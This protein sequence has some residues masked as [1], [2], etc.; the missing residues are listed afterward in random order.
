MASS[1]PIAS[2]LAQAGGGSSGFS[3]GG[4]GGGGSFSGSSG[5]GSGGSST[6]AWVFVGLAVLAVVLAAVVKAYRARRREEARAAREAQARAAAAEAVADDAGF[7]ADAVVQRAGGL[8][9]EVQAAWDARDRGRLAALLGP[10]LLAEW[11]R[12]LDDFDAKGWH[13]HVTVTGDPAVRLVGLR[14]QEGAADDRVVV[15]VAADIDAWVATDDGKK[16]YRDGAKTPHVHLEQYWTL[17]RRAERDGWIL[18][19]IEEEAE[20]RHQLDAPLVATPAADPA[21]AGRTRTELATADA[22]GPAADVAALTS[23]T[24]DARAAALDLALVD[25]RFSPDVLTVA[26][27]ELVAAW[28]EAVDGDDAALERRADPG[29]VQRLLYG[30]DD[31]RRVRTV[32]RG[33]RVQDVTID[34]LDGRATP[35]TMSVTIRYEGAWYRE[36]RDTQ[37]VV[38]GA[39]ERVTTRREQWTLGLTG[40]AARPWRLVRADAP[41]SR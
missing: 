38:A 21:L 5:S 12:R 16:R 27:Q 13:S 19:S 31:A 25:D 24:G 23:I 7:D 15:F 2:L 29:A 30:D 35:P 34:A 20:G 40:D 1:P 9:R 28:G 14:N 17:G 11:V 26:V 10:D 41:P 36:D 4:G 37:A 18:L 39:R 22:A 33:L 6:G 32:V 8:F 3:G